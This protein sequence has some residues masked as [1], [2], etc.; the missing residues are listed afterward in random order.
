MELLAWIK[1]KQE[2]GQWRLKMG[3]GAGRKRKRL[4]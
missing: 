1:Q 4:R 2:R 3:W